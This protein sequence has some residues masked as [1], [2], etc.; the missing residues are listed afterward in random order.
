MSRLCYP[1]LWTQGGQATG[2][3]STEPASTGGMP[4]A[5][6]LTTLIQEDHVHGYILFYLYSH[7]D[8]AF[9]LGLP[10]RWRK[11]QRRKRSCHLH[12]LLFCNKGW[13]ALSKETLCK[14]RE[15]S[16]HSM[17]PTP[18]SRKPDLP[19]GA[20]QLQDRGQRSP[21]P[22]EGSRTEGRGHP[23]HWKAV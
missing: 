9:L 23:H 5:M 16:P 17:L 2:P 14:T 19:P 18:R 15:Q 1:I 21:T 11:T 10:C 4:E 3:K 20:S 12:P 8:A 6:F 13:G 22:L 7:Q